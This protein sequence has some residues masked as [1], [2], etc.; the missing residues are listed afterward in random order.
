MSK[1]NV[2]IPREGHYIEKIL[3]TKV[4]QNGGSQALRIPAVWRFDQNEVYARVDDETGDLI[5]SRTNPE[6]LS[7]FFAALAETGPIAD[8]G[9]ELRDSDYPVRAGCEELLTDNP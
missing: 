4:F 1:L 8:D 3:K 7:R 5:L 2:G 9:L 6:P